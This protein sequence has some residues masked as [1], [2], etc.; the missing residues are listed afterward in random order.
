MEMEFRQYD[1][2]IARF[3][4]IDPVTHHSMSTFAAYDNN[5]VFW[6]DPTG[7]DSESDYD[8]K[9]K[10]Y[11]SGSFGAAMANV[12]LNTDGTPSQQKPKSKARK[13]RDKYVGM[14]NDANE[15]GYHVAADNLQRWL[16]GT[17]GTKTLDSEWLKSFRAVRKAEDKNI[18]RFE[19]QL[20][21]LARGLKD[22]GTKNFTDYW[23][24]SL[25]P[26]AYSE[27]YYAS[28]TSQLT[29]TGSFT[30]K[31]KGDKIY[32]S[33]TIH[34][35]WNDP[36][37]WHKGLNAGV[38]VPGNGFVKDSDAILV[39]REFGAKSFHM[40]SSWSNSVSTSSSLWF[41]GTYISI[42]LD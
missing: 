8:W 37:N 3:T 2:A 11:R 34:H 22:G 18:G 27:L 32:I 13:A 17:G 7:A 29:S 23:D 36:Y 25:T 10:T 40:K 35:E 30:L 21:K 6:A 33:G 39:E 20:A 14:I 5:P 12:G 1:P 19:A 9:T 24:A 16:D 38:S 42:D 26:N 31:R 28:G 4:S 15:D 41:F